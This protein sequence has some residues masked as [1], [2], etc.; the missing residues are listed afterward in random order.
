MG[1]NHISG[2]ADCLRCC[3]LRWTVSVVNWWWS[4]SPVYHTDHRHLCTTQWAWV[5]V[6][7]HGSVSGSGDLQVISFSVYWC[8]LSV[9][10]KLVLFV[11]LVFKLFPLL[12]YF[13]WCG[14]IGHI[15][16]G[17]Y[18]WADVND[19]IFSRLHTFLEFWYWTVICLVQNSLKAYH[20]SAWRET[21]MLNSSVSSRLLYNSTF[22]WEAI[23]WIT[24]VLHI[25]CYLI[26]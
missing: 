7:W 3:H 16:Y 9:C 19:V 15:L 18:S 20:S 17:W 21:K 13:T 2:T 22:F 5:T 10:N 25:V 24:N 11:E 4:R 8:T 14:E 26:G 1:T 6:S 12:E 23:Q